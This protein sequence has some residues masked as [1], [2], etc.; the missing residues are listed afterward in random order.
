M[1]SSACITVKGTSLLAVPSC[2]HIE[3]GYVPGSFTV[4]EA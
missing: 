3:V 1:P 4:S 2:Y